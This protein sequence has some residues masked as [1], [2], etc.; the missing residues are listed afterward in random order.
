MSQ[1]VMKLKNPVTHAIRVFS[2][3]GW[4]ILFYY[5]NSEYFTITP[6]SLLVWKNLKT[7]QEVSDKWN[8]ISNQAPRLATFLPFHSHGSHADLGT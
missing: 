7:A 3:I 5:L 1:D 6:K 4:L 2:K 8:I